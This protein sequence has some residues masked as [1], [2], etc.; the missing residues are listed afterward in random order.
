MIFGSTWGLIQVL[1]NK[2]QLKFQVKLKKD[3]KKFRYR[4]DVV[5]ALETVIKLL[6]A[7]K[8][9]PAKYKD[10]FLSGN[11]IGYRECHLK[12]DVLLIYTTDDETL[13]LVRIGSHSELF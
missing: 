4:Q 12:P 9:L 7:Q 6:L 8:K 3:F 13:F 11:Y 5:N 2:F 10:H 1:K